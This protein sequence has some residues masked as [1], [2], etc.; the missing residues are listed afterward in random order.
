[1]PLFSSA[2]D[3]IDVPNDARISSLEAIAR[4]LDP[5]AQERHEL[6]RCAHQCV[7][8]MLSGLPERGAFREFDVEASSSPDLTLFSIHEHAD[9]MDN[10]VSILN[11][12]VFDHGL[13]CSSGGDLSYV[14]GRC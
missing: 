6:L 3:A 5:D 9:S 10:T 2:S 1:M 11:K 4:K 13:S 7:T 8:S 14:P 12:S